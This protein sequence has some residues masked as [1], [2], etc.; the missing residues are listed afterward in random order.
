MRQSANGDPKLHTVL[1]GDP[2]AMWE[3]LSWDVD[4]FDDV[5]RSYPTERQP[6]AYAALNACLAASSLADWV[7]KCYRVGAIKKA[8]T[9]DAFRRQI[10]ANIE[11]QELCEAIANTCKHGA[12]RAPGKVEMLW[13]DSD[14]DV[15]GGFRL[16]HSSPGTANTVLSL[17]LFRGLLADWWSF[18]VAL[19]LAQGP[20][21]TPEWEQNKLHRIFGGRLSG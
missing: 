15:P 20:R 21:P 7:D 14:E 13:H 11:N 3:K 19:G 5:Q 4:Q 16:Y 1:I 17:E 6:L 8:T 12:Y 9:A 2:L 18:L 10:Y